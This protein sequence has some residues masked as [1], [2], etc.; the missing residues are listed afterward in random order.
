MLERLVGVGLAGLWLL[1]L[2]QVVAR[3][4]LPVAPAW[5]EEIARLVFVY[6]TFGAATLAL[7]R[8][9]NMQV[10]TLVDRLSPASRRAVRVAVN[11][12]SGAFLLVVFAWSFVVIVESWA[13][14]LPASDL[15]T[16]LFMLPVPVGAALMVRHVVGELRRDLARRD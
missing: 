10:T 7:G 11:L 8:G 5:T 13:L 16:A 2:F 15:P 4:L 9:A 6:L 1:L 14:P 3:Y 12:G